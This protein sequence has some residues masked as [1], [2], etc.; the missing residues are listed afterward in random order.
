MLA[1]SNGSADTGQHQMP[2][3]CIGPGYGAMGR[4]AHRRAC[5]ALPGGVAGTTHH[6][7]AV[8]R[9]AEITPTLLRRAPL[10]RAGPFFMSPVEG[11]S[12]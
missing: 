2:F 1:R 7:E 11:R 5:A 10:L 9:L 4:T 12:L 6:I 3:T 8:V